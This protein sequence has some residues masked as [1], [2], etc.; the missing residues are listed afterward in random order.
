MPP[1]ARP[2]DG[3]RHAAV[4]CRAVRVLLGDGR[5]GDAGAGNAGR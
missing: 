4:G 3:D 1:K 2:G 5:P